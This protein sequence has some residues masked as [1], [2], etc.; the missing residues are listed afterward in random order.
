MCCLRPHLHPSTGCRVCASRGGWGIRSSVCL[1][2]LVARRSPLVSA[3]IAAGSVLSGLPQSSMPMCI[4]QFSIVLEPSTVVFRVCCGTAIHGRLVG[5]AYRSIYS[6]TGSP[7]QR[8][9]L[10]IS[11]GPFWAARSHNSTRTVII[12]IC[13]DSFIQALTAKHR[14]LIPSPVI[15]SHAHCTT[16]SSGHGLGS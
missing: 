7:Q 12:F 10:S 14:M 1:G 4:L 11:E 8:P 13:V 3:L 6:L 5:H 15:Y 2:W 9:H 16:H